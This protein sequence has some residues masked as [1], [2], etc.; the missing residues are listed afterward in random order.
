MPHSGVSPQGDDYFSIVVMMMMVSSTRLSRHVFTQIG[1]NA[2]PE[3]GKN[4]NGCPNRSI[5]GF[6][7]GFPV[8]V[9]N[10]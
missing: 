5:E 7:E 4:E 10:G 9:N 3:E 8:K 6:H 1:S 2:D